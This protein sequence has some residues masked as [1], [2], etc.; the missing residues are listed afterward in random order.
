MKSLKLWSPIILAGAMIVIAARFGTVPETPAWL[1]KFIHLDTIGHLALYFLLGLFVARYFSVGLRMGAVGT[2]VLTAA[3]AVTAGV[4]DEVHQMFVAGRNAEFRDLAPDLVGGLVAA[5]IYLWISFVSR[6]VRQSNYAAEVRVGLIAGMAGVIVSAAVMVAI[7]GVFYSITVA[8]ALAPAA[9]E[10]AGAGLPGRGDGNTVHASMTL[11][12]VSAE[13]TK[14]VSKAAQSGSAGELEERLIRTVLQDVV[15]QMRRELSKQDREDPAKDTT[16]AQAAPDVSAVDNGAKTNV[17][18]KVAHAV[19]QMIS[20]PE[21]AAISPTVIA[22]AREKILAALRNNPGLQQREQGHA[23]GAVEKPAERCDLVAVLAHP[24]NPV[25][26]LT[27]DQARKLFSGEYVNWSQ[28]GGPNLPVKVIT[29][30]KRNEGVTENVKN[31]LKAPLA[32]DAVS[33]PLV[34]FIIPSVAQ[35]KG[36]VGFLPVSNVEQ[37]DFVAGHSAFKRIAIK[38]DNESP[39]RLPNRMALN[40]K[41]YPIMAE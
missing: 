17:T 37:L 3:I 2:L 1:D 28:V 19:K 15:H 23:L 8:P 26:E 12:Q 34:S 36:A 6:V 32:P 21:A 31:H 38:S 13:P 41:T 24:S 27:L 5:L 33:L 39:G 30:S 22:G 20:T 29:V 35:N 11:A 9:Q 16:H 25:R 40:T 10:A 4:C 14:T 7:F 18:D